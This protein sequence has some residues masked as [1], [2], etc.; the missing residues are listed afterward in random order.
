[1]T[2]RR[3]N[4]LFSVFMLLAASSFFTIAGVSSAQVHS[5]QSTQLMQPEQV[6]L[7]AQPESPVSRHSDLITPVNTEPITIDQVLERRLA[8]VKKSAKSAILL[9]A[10]G[11][12]AAAIKLAREILVGREG[13]LEI[14][15]LPITGRM[16]AHPN[17]GPVNDSA[18]AA[19]EFATGRPISLHELSMGRDGKPIQTLWEYAKTQG[20]RVGLVSDTRLTHATPAAFACHQL[21][22][23]DE[24][25]IAIQMLNSGFDVML[26][27]GRRMFAS[28]KSTDGAAIIDPV[29]TAHERGYQVI[30]HGNEFQ[31]AVAKRSE[32]VLGLF[33]DSFMAYSYDEGKSEEPTLDTMTAGALT[34]LSN[35]NSRFLL[36]VEAGKIDSTMHGHDAAELVYQMNVMENTLRVLRDYV[37][38][39]QDTLL[40]VVSNHSNGG[41]SL[42]ENFDP[43]KFKSIATSSNALSRYLIDRGDDI[44]A[45]MKRLF[46]TLTFS[47]FEL[48]DLTV[49]S[50][51]PEFSAAVGSLLYSRLGLYFLPLDA[52]RGMEITHG[53]TG[54]DLFIHAQGVHQNLFGGT[55]RI[56]EVGK[57]IATALGLNFP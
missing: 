54:E 31:D 38:L 40:V 55:M 19:S 12:N 53:H 26:S 16:I 23:E 50:K 44:P 24:Y 7:P 22:R 47:E 42:T 30:L 56:W 1:M 9:I 18:A 5:S 21:G 27:G 57:R 3:V 8:N 52:Q 45:I 28:C 15:R 2:V 6:P 46:P 4:M 10:D 35:K 25:A 20:F 14:D 32:K 51:S 33:A 41:L 36:M 17:D 48:H 43:A 37:N 34:L 39:H 13:L 49:R 29:S 11:M